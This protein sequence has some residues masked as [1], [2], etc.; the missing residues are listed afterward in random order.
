MA[1]PPDQPS[2]AEF[3]RRHD[4]D[5]FLCA[6]F[7]PAASREAIFTLIAF[8][9]EL[10]RAREAAREPMMVLIRLQWWRDAVEEAVARRP[11]RRHEVAGP[12][13]RAIA[14]G[15]LDPA[16]LLAMIDAR[17]GDETGEGAP[18]LPERLRGTAGALAAETGR[19]LG[20][21][22]ERMEGLRLLGTAYG[23]GG[24]LRSLSALAAQGRDPLPEG[25]DPV[26]AGR[27]LAR[28]GLSILDAG[29]KAAVGLPR[30]AVAAALP[31]V[32]AQR[33]LQRVLSPGWQPG[34]PPAPRGLGDRLAV[35][36]AGLRGRV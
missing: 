9:H 22:P 7:A 20:A 31:A 18:P 30:G 17:E 16:A 1:E 14:N 19:L 12:V 28:K 26:D 21:P 35:A 24:T 10:A 15:S 2:L 3:A 6:L 11:A 4:P 33:D 23:F 8:N 32:L 25:A 29:R 36:W 34:A 27:V 13:S 5:R